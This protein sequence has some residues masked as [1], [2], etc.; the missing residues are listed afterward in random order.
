MWYFSD[1]RADNMS[2]NRSHAEATQLRQPQMHVK[3]VIKDY[4][5]TSM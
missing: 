1:T 3:N 4:K 5:D 2:K